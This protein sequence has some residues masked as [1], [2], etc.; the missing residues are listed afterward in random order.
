MT[1]STMIHYVKSVRAGKV[2]YENDNAV[3]LHIAQGDTD[4][5]LTLFGLSTAD[6]EHLSRSLSR[7]ASSMTEDE[8]R[9]DE[10]ARVRA[11][12]GL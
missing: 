10:R 8:I 12:L 9:A 4:L 2:S 6:A 11:R 3:T 1:T 5:S 7:D